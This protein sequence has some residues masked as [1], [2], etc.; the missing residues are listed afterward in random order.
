MATAAEA[1]RS[2]SAPV[3]SSSAGRV[4]VWRSSL[5]VL[6]THP[7]GVGTG[8]VTDELTAV[9]EQG[10]IDYA[11]DRK[12]NPHNQWLQAGVAFGWAGVLVFSLILWSWLDMA[13]HRRSVIGFLCGTCFSCMLLWNP[14]WRSSG[15]WCSS[16]LWMAIVEGPRNRC[17]G[18]E[19]ALPAP[20]EPTAFDTAK[21]PFQL[22]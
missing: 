20:S 8:D 12:L 15:A 17:D 13:W 4:A 10:G 6:L 2:E 1:I 9:Y 14:F 11:R 7:W 3:A 18:T 19:A 16:W 5:D 21:M 22:L